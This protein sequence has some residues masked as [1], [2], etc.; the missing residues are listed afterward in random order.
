M[1]ALVLCQNL[2]R[3]AS[4][5]VLVGVILQLWGFSEAPNTTES[6]TTAPPSTTIENTTETSPLD[7]QKV[8]ETALLSRR[9]VC[10]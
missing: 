4:Q 5:L 2:R 7:T 1:L 9:H 6:T 8:A 10:D 3:V